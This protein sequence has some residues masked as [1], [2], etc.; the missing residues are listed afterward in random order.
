MQ[1]RK[2]KRIS[3]SELENIILQYYRQVTNDKDVLSVKIQ[4]SNLDG[5]IHVYIEEKKFEDN[6]NKV[7]S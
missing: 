2:Y 3:L 6:L 1:N 4:G 5:G 7:L